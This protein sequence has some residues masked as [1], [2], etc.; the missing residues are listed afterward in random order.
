MCNAGWQVGGRK[1]RPAYEGGEETFVALRL[2]P[3]RKLPPMP[4][5]GSIT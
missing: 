3:G 4:H 1:L 2:D 5:L